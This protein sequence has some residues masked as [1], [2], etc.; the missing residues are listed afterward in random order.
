MTLIG[1]VERERSR[2]LRLLRAAIS[3][4]ALASVVVVL[5]L[6]AL[7]LGGARWI[8]L[9]R[10]VPFAVWALAGS[11]AV[12][13]IR[14]GMRAVSS[15]ASPVAIAGALEREQQLRDGSLRG[16]VELASNQSAF[17]KRASDRLAA[18]L[19]PL[20]S[21]LAPTME[22]D[23]VRGAARAAAVIVPAVL[24]GSFV[25]AGSGDGWRALAHPVDAWRGALL[26]PIEIVDVPTRLLRGS[27]LKL[28]VKAGGRPAVSLM[29]RSTGNAWIE[30]PL[31][32]TAGTVTTDIGPLDADVT[33]VVSD[34]RSSSDTAV[35]RIVDRPFLGDV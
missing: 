13:M 35:I 2:A 27:S 29:R 4:R 25:A 20:Q 33:L 24:I 26:P 5:A 32:L 19:A 30:T 16:L 1:I 31:I 10:I 34:G 12:W 15:D 28:T 14:R 8:A 18:R 17:V 11:L 3:A 23:L 22:R 9:P 7:L 21:P 6:G